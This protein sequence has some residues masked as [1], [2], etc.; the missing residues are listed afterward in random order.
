MQKR[1]RAEKEEE[2]MISQLSQRSSQFQDERRVVRQKYRK[3]IDML[4]GM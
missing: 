3:R 4:N 1:K 2:E